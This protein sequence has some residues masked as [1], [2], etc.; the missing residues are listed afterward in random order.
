MGE[1]ASHFTPEQ[2]AAIQDYFERMIAAL[3]GETV[4]LTRRLT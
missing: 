4:K 2:L 1:V 3:R